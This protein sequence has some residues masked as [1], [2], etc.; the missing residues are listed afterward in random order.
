[1][2]RQ[3]TPGRPRVSDFSGCFFNHRPVT[4]CPVILCGRLS[5]VQKESSPHPSFRIPI[6]ARS[7]QLSKKIA[8]VKT[9]EV[10]MGADAPIPPLRSLPPPPQGRS[11]GGLNTFSFCSVE[12]I[13][14][15]SF[16]GIVRVTPS[17]PKEEGGT[18]KGAS[19]LDP[20]FYHFSFKSPFTACSTKARVDETPSARGPIADQSMISGRFSK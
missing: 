15:V 11:R 14:M 7:P 2:S 9:L 6:P 16:C 4:A 10:R 18:P 1:M 13:P 20:R 8:L 3:N 19:P 17:L 12:I 5:G